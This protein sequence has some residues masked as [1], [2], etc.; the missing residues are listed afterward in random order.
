MVVNLFQHFSMSLGSSQL[1]ST[2]QPM[3]ILQHQ[4]IYFY[5]S[6]VRG[7]CG[8]I[9]YECTSII[10][11]WN[12]WTISSPNFLWSLIDMKNFISDLSVM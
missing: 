4:N 6:F 12:V 11:G 7:P 9:V 10:R 1:G 8:I 5:D 3:W 2:L